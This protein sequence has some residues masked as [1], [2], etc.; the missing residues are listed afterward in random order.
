M[1][2]APTPDAGP[3]V[4]FEALR[5]PMRMRIL[6][7]L[8]EGRSSPSELA[9]EFG[10]S[11]GA[12]DYHLRRLEALGVVRI[13]EERPAQGRRGPPQHYYGPESLSVSDAE[14][15]SIPATIRGALT[16]AVLRELAR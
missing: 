8:D 1:N 4:L 14:W 11:I 16:T 3:A 6:T 15:K 13:V 2:G 5:H 9:A 12:V 10:M 7:R